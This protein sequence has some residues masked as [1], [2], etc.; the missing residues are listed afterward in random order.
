MADVF[1][2][3][4]ISGYDSSPPA[5]DGSQVAAN[6]VDWDTIKDK[7]TDPVKILAEAIA[8]EADTAFD[9]V[10]GI[11]DA[12]SAKTGAY[13]VVNADN[14]TLFLLSAASADYAITLPS[15]ATVG[16]GF[17]IGFKKTDATKYMI[18]LTPNGSDT[19][20]GLPNLKLRNPGSQGV[21]VSDAGNW[22]VPSHNNVAIEYN[23]SENSGFLVDQYG[24][25]TRT[26]AGASTA[27]MQDRWQI[28]TAGSASGRFTYSNESAGGVDG[29]S[30]WAKFLCTTADASP[31]ASEALYIRHTIIGN[32]LAGAGFLGSDGLFENG[33]LSMDIIGHQNSGSAP[34]TATIGIH[35]LDGTAR[36]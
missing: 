19:I 7:L 28:V 4:T 15:A 34:W 9:T 23:A 2:K 16:D 6:L 36:S 27:H 33:V 30:K 21:L 31:G 18:T 11:W 20:D 25:I 8:D 26:G 32:T 24:H 17:R 22:H 10:A 5:N 14:G 29:K 35:T 12:T 3:P 1:T 13:T